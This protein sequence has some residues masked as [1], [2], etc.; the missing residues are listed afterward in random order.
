VC[1][2]HPSLDEAAGDAAVRVDPESAA[3]ISRGIEEARDRRDE[4]VTKGLAHAGRF[5]W[6]ATGEA[7]L[8]GYRSAA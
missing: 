7:I 1:S 8:A 6:R 2:N 5:T 3:G 4:L